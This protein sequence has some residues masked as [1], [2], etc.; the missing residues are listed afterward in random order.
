M[1]EKSHIFFSLNYQKKR[2]IL[3]NISYNLPEFLHN[4]LKKTP[5]SF[6]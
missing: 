6:L 5:N 2:W 4:L 1:Q 3:K